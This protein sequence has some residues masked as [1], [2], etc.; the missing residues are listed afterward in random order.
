MNDHVKP[1]LRDFNPE[2]IILHVGTNDLSTKRT[3]SQIVKSVI[4]FCQSLKTDAINI[5]VSLIVPRYDNLSNKASEVNGTLMN[6]FKKRN[7][8]HIDHTDKISQECH[9]NE[10]N[11]HLNRYELLAFCNKF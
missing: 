1:T 6:I 5:T 8:S 2:H 3:A 4:E 11:L 10:S 7:I 9:L